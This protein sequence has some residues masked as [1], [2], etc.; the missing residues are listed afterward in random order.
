MVI[1]IFVVLLIFGFLGFS[2]NLPLP[3]GKEDINYGTVTIWGT[4]PRDVMSRLIGDTL[5]K[6]THVKINYSEKKKETFNSDFVESLARGNGPDLVLLPQDR[7]PKAIDKLSLIP[8]TAMSER[9]FKNTFIQEGEMFLRPG[10]IAAMP[11]SIDPIVMFWNRD[12]FTNA[13]VVSPPSLWTEFYDLVPKITIRDD[14][15]NVTRSLVSFGEYGNVSHAKE[16]ISLLM[17]Q[18]G[19]PI[20]S[21]Q[22]GA[23]TSALLISTEGTGSESPVAAAIRFY[24]EFSKPGK[25]AYSWNRS[26]PFS[27]SMFESGDL[28]LYFGYASEYKEISSKNPHLNFDVA[29][30]PQAGTDAKA[31]KGL[32][33]LTFGQMQGIAIVK[34]SKNQAGAQYVALLISSKD[35]IAPYTVLSGLPP[36]RR[37]LVAVRP[38]DAVQSIFY[39]SALIS[40]GWYDPSSDDSNALFRGMI[41]DITS[42]RTLI[43]EALSA[44]DGGMGRLLIQTNK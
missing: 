41:D 32:S 17:M 4:L 36:V 6:D 44:A 35:A 33:K 7:I 25:D 42:G 27:R 16:I 38:S 12:L 9:D 39:D 8:Y 28:A 14:Q 23:A 10:G 43:S 22:N 13:L 1:G 24:T 31:G 3:G 20:V 18:A 19:S 15:G 30:V 5:S 26:L 40:R 29:M 34:S 2:G 21:Y 37:D 11:F